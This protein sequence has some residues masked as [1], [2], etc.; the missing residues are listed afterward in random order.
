MPSSTFDSAEGSEF[1]GKSAG[2]DR[3]EFRS[4]TTVMDRLGSDPK[5]HD[6]L[7]GYLLERLN[8]SERRMDQF[9][10][11]WRINER[12]VQGYISLPKYDEV[13]KAMNESG[14][15][16][17]PV[18]ITLPYAYATAWTV[19][20]Y[21]VHTF[22][23]RKPMFQVSS[24][25]TETAQSARMMELVLQ[26]NV[27][28]T[29][30]IRQLFQMFMDGEVYGVGIVRT[31]WVEKKAKRSEF[32]EVGGF[33]GLLNRAM[34]GAAKQRQKVDKLI[35]QGNEAVSV[36]PF[37]FFPDPNVPMAE[38][39]RK[40]EYVFW[41]AFTGKHELLLAQ[42]ADQV[43]YVDK[44]NPMS[45][46]QIQSGSSAGGGSVRGVAF[47]ADANA[48]NTV[49]G[50][51]QG[52]SNY[53]QV[54]QGSVMVIPKELGLGDSMVPE[55]WLFTMLN[56]TQIIQ[57][58]PLDV[59]YDM[60]PVSVIEP[61]TFGYGFG[62]PG[63][64]DFVGPVQDT[65]SWLLNSHIHNVRAV[66]NNSFIVDP[67]MVEMQDLKSTEPGKLIRL[68]RAAFGQDVRQAIQQLPVSD[69]TRGHIADLEVFQRLGDA[70]TGVNDNLRGVQDSGGRKT[71]T[72]VRT[73][74]EAGASRLAAQARLT[75]AQG[76]VD[77]TEQMTVNLQYKLTD[78]VYLSITG[79]AG[80]NTPIKIS[81]ESITGDFY[82]PVHDGTLPIDRVAMFDLW[83][84]L[85]LGIAQ[86]Q[87]LRS[88]FS[89]PNIFEWVAKLGGAENIDSFKVQVAAPEAAPPPG[90]IPLNMDV[91]R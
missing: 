70:L 37:M 41:R 90:A 75:S 88:N 18:S 15:P 48:A 63:M 72:E 6:H 56:K 39:N 12:K 8:Y 25:K 82:Y 29:R 66:L 4:G 91:A 14:K 64:V 28:A 50:G 67:S 80:V 71:A 34:G 31:L 32:V 57:A 65:M 24:Y 2:E 16:P 7:R 44:V 81:P 38:V 11:R 19:V 78:P 87:E 35:F 62:Q 21:M 1:L 22:C 83:K 69:V 53:Y 84:E 3:P 77:L 51:V 76:I 46:G 55:R 45:P 79:S 68:K 40:G 73:S 60:H 20:T 52:P 58:E 59:E 42:A 5:F 85:L 23:G 54:D 89:V 74:N 33:Q 27:D 43:R 30:L 13:L 9:Y 61:R 26:W 49:R 10:P 36:D 17:S 47:G 86:D